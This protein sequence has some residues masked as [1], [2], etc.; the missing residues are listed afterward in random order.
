MYVSTNQI[1]YGVISYMRQD[2]LPKLQG[3]KR[4][5][6]G[7]A[8]TLVSEKDIDKDLLSNS[9][10]AMLGITDTNGMIDLDRLKEAICSQL[11]GQKMPIEIPVIGTFKFGQSDVEKLARMIESVGDCR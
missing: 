10:I 9:T 11:G 3:W 1:K 6:L 5:A 8:M 2:M 7:T 4:V